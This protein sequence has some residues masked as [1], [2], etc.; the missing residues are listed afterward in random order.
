M[1]ERMLQKTCTIRHRS[2]DESDVNE[3]GDPE[4]TSTETEAPCELQ[5]VARDEPAGA[6][7]IAVTEWVLFLPDGTEL[8]TTDQVVIDGLVYEVTGEPEEAVS[9]HNR[10]G[11]V[12]A[13]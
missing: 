6:G 7:E 8:D 9:V 10:W 13:T 4:I 2:E 1:F 11:F 12:E 5:Q 3:Y